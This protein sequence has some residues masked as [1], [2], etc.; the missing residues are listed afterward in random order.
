METLRGVTVVPTATI[1]RSPKGTYVFLVKE[2]ETV[3]VRWVDEPAEGEN[4]SIVEEGLSPVT[5]LW[6]RVD[7]VVR[8]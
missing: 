5:P 4:I 8:S 1:Q 7:D 2:D 3:T 6:R